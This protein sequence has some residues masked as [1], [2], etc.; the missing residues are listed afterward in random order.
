MNEVIPARASDLG[1][2]GRNWIS[3]LGDIDLK[4][5]DLRVRPGQAMRDVTLA[6]RSAF[7][8]SDAGNPEHRV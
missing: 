5:T 1:Q 8:P 7:T 3:A 6:W 2:K 4:L